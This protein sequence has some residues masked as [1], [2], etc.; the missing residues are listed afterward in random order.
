MIEQLLKVW[1][2]IICGLAVGDLL[3]SLFLMAMRHP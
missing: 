1:V 3:G 2:A